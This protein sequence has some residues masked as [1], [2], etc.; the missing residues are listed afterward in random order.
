ML[1][2]FLFVFVDV[3]VAD[4][5]VVFVVRVWVQCC[6]CFVSDKRVLIPCFLVSINYLLPENNDRDDDD[7]IKKKKPHL[8]S[9]G[10]LKEPECLSRSI[11]IS[12]TFDAE[13]Y[14]NSCTL[15]T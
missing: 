15:A 11:I 12:S 6:S 9:K 10:N 5:T 7:R 3:I 4:A 8:H 14:A 1:L 13:R 2:C